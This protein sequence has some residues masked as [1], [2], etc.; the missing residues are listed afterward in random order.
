MPSIEQLV[1]TNMFSTV[2]YDRF[3]A[4]DLDM[5]GF[6]A[7]A[8]NSG[9]DGEELHEGI[10]NQTLNL[11]GVVIYKQCPTDQVLHTSSVLYTPSQCTYMTRDLLY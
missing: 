3:A 11:K 10:I 8:G 9:L 5:E 6:C 2:Y 4:R 1:N 7:A